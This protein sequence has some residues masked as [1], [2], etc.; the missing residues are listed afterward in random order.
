MIYKNL[1]YC[2]RFVQTWQINLYCISF[3]YLIPHY[4]CFGMVTCWRLPCAL[5]YPI[6]FSSITVTPKVQGKCV[7]REDLHRWWYIVGQSKVLLS[8]W[9]CLFLWACERWGHVFQLAGTHLWW[10]TWYT[11]WLIYYRYSSRATEET[12]VTLWRCQHTSNLLHM[13]VASKLQYNSVYLI[14]TVPSIEADKQ[15]A[16]WIPFHICFTK[17][18]ICAYPSHVLS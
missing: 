2:V 12:L 7:L 3:A 13:I 18:A 6:L 1:W 16:Y 15:I 4:N 11:R 9:H 17:C 8:C 5:T 10:N 14:I